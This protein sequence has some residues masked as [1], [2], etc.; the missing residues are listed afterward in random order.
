M[1]W[2][3]SVVMIAVRVLNGCGRLGS[4]S[5]TTYEPSVATVNASLS[6]ASFG[7]SV[8]GGGDKLS[9]NVPTTA[10]VES[11]TLMPISPDPAA[12]MIPTTCTTYVP[13]VASIVNDPASVSGLPTSLP[14]LVT[15]RLTAVR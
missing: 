4:V 13:T 1:I 12:P 15:A 5:V 3:A 7:G 11:V 14:L 2:P 8:A 10:P 6:A 9:E